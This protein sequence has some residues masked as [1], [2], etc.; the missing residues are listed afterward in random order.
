[1]AFCD[2]RATVERVALCSGFVFFVL[3]VGSEQHGVI[4]SMIGLLSKL[5]FSGIICSIFNSGYGRYVGN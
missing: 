1:M 5:V 2:A 4:F 3:F